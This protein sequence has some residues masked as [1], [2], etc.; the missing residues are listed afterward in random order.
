MRWGQW[1]EKGRGCSH[2]SST[3]RALRAKAATPGAPRGE[4]L[5]QKKAGIMPTRAFQGPRA[6]PDLGDFGRGVRAWGR[7]PQRT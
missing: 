2:Q 5:Q 7:G 3:V 1:G 4:D 6:P